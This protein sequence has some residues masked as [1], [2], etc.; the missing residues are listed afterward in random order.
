MK[1]AL[2]SG[3]DWH[4]L[5]CRVR[6]PKVRLPAHRANGFP[7]ATQ[8]QSP[9]RQGGYKKRHHSE[10]KTCAELL[11]PVRV[12]LAMTKDLEED[13]R[14]ALYSSKVRRRPEIETPHSEHPQYRPAAPPILRRDRHCPK[15]HLKHCD[16]AAI[17]YLDL[18]EP[19]IMKTIGKQWFQFSPSHVVYLSFFG[20]PLRSGH[21]LDWREI[22]FARVDL[23]CQN[24]LL[25]TSISLSGCNKVWIQL[26]PLV[27]HTLTCG[28]DCSEFI[29]VESNQ[30]TDSRNIYHH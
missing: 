21:K 29:F 25:V 28:G 15:L 27:K 16:P 24:T 1:Y 6:Q 10:N 4:L 22:L 18:I 26:L 19:A 3:G 11:L 9:Q 13:A 20:M 2:A 12:P 5:Q 8:T 23:Q 17:I 14:Q 30:F 7:S